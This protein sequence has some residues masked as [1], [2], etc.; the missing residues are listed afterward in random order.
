MKL[1]KVILKCSQQRNYYV[2]AESP[3][4]AYSKARQ[5]FNERNLGLN[6]DVALIQIELIAEDSISPRCG[7]RLYT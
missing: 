3:T 7:A 5:D 1:Y 6:K 4:E 2:A